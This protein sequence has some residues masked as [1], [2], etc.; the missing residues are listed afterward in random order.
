MVLTPFGS[1]RFLPGHIPTNRPS[2]DFHFPVA[3][4]GRSILYPL[5]TSS[6]LLPWRL[7]PD[8]LYA[9]IWRLERGGRPD[10]QAGRT[11]RSFVSRQPPYILW[12]LLKSRYSWFS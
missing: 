1:I 3:L 12:N 2:A 11:G 5:L 6:L 10:F 4:P 9:P 7:P 8:L